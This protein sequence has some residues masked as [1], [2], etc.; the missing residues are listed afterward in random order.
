VAKYP[1]AASGNDLDEVILATD[2]Y[3][4]EKI[5]AAWDVATENRHPCEPMVQIWYSDDYQV[6]CLGTTNQPYI[7]E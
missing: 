7:L 2:R 5:S 3:Y 4:S 1:L 6:V